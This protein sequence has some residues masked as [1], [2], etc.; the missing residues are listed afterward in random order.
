MS[1]GVE[2]LAELC[3]A[4][5]LHEVNDAAALVDLVRENGGDLGAKKGRGEEEK[6]EGPRESAAGVMEGLHFVVG[7]F[8]VQ[9][10]RA[11]RLAGGGEVS[12]STVSR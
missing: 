7:T 10:A 9:A 5:V 4:D 12:A 3:A 2:V 11:L 8:R 6:A 1:I